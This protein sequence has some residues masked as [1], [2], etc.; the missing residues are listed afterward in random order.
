MP[1]TARPS[2]S[3]RRESSTRL[4]ME[5]LPVRAGGSGL[6]AGS[7]GAYTDHPDDDDDDDDSTGRRSAR[8]PST[9]QQTLYTSLLPIRRKRGRCRCLAIMAT[10]LAT[11]T[12][13][14]VTVIRP[15]H[16]PSDPRSKLAQPFVAG[17]KKLQDSATHFVD[18]SRICPPRPPP[19]P[20][21]PNPILVNAS[22]NKHATASWRPGLVVEETEERLRAEGQPVLNQKHVQEIEDGWKL[23]EDDIGRGNNDQGYSE[24]LYPPIEGYGAL[25][26]S[27]NPWRERFL[28]PTYACNEQETGSQMHVRQLLHLAKALNRTL[29]LPNWGFG[30]PTV[31][32]CRPYS[33]DMI[34]ET[35]ST[36]SVGLW[37]ITYPRWI[38]YIRNS[39]RKFNARISVIFFR[40][41]HKALSE[42]IGTDD[43]TTLEDA[44]VDPEP[45]DISD[46]PIYVA[47]NQDTT[48]S[49]M[50]R[51]L[52]ETDNL[53]TLFVHFNHY[54]DIRIADA[55]PF[56][57]PLLQ[58]RPKEWGFWV[59]AAWPQWNYSSQ[60][61]QMFRT[62]QA[63]L[64]EQYGGVQWRMELMPPS[65]LKN[66][67]NLFA[68]S[69]I[70]GMRQRG[71][72][73]IYIAS[74]MPLTTQRK[75]SKSASFNWDKVLQAKEALDNL[76]DRLK[77]AHLSIMTWNDIK[78]SPNDR[79]IIEG[80]ADTASG[81]FDKLVLGQSERL[82]AANP[83]CGMHSSFLGTLQ[84]LRQD[85]I[86]D[87]TEEDWE[88]LGISWIGE[89]IKQRFWWHI[90]G[91]QKDYTG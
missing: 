14:I 55:K 25:S 57:D 10:F 70:E 82:W 3:A 65:V 37:S 4:L 48:L 7:Q 31:S 84:I 62:A 8:R 13:I 24:P 42:T 51:H 32:N 52:R 64:P 87:P 30:I 39:E 45:F 28:V 36:N 59:G 44:C 77:G 22:V 78:P 72:K 83:H 75:N 35:E 17:L 43:A 88:K 19:C 16:D 34:Y 91:G 67:S 15:Q 1:V 81:I 12:V 6:G 53:S 41:T 79:D 27:D 20:T 11:L 80:L 69:V 33:F 46:P 71:L 86:G 49:Y 26:R 61:Q 40:N 21:C 29:V 5:P 50:V 63:H 56:P 73:T 23:H 58:V 9:L 38:K 89:P 68:E 85:R 90:K 66:C 2:I 54:S 74:D 47:T 18:S 60:V 76:V